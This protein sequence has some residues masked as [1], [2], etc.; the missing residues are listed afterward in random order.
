MSSY[1]IRCRD[2]NTQYVGI[3]K[4]ITELSNFPS[5]GRK[6]SGTYRTKYLIQVHGLRSKTLDI[7]KLRNIN[8][9][10][11]DVSAQHIFHFDSL[12]SL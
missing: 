4:K 6:K 9:I 2:K 5:Q 12:K 10:Q 1:G 3:G 8:L 11:W 7:V